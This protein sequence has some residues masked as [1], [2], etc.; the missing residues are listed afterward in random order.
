MFIINQVFF[1]HK[2]IMNADFFCVKCRHKVNAPVLGVAQTKNG[3]YQAKGKC[4]HC[5]TTLNKFVSQQEGSGFLGKLF[6][7][8][9]KLNAK[10]PNWSKIPILG[11]LI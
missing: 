10:L 9:D 4:S 7:F 8:E 1:V 11:K 3:R 2:K 5:G 6:G